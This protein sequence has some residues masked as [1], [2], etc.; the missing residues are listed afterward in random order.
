[1]IS[2]TRSLCSVLLLLTCLHAAAQN[3][4]H[5]IFS[6]AHT[7]AT[8]GRL[9]SI[10]RIDNERF[11]PLSFMGRN[12]ISL[13]CR[14][15][16]PPAGKPKARYPMI[17]I[18][19]GSGA[20]GT[21]NRSQ[22]GLMAKYWARDDI[23]SRYPAY[24]LAVQF[25]TR[26]SDY[27]PDQQRGIPVS[28]HRP[29]LETALQLVDSLR[30]S[31]AVDPARIYGLGYS[32][33]ASTIL[34]AIGLRSNLFAGVVSISGVPEFSHLALLKRVPLLLVHGNADTENVFAGSAQ[35]FKELSNSP[36]NRVQFWEIK[37]AT[38]DM[39]N[40]WLSQELPAWLFA[41]KKK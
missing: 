26:S 41:Q 4:R 14:L 29:C 5:R 31:L 38:H 22:L 19:H 9:D 20:V 16:P 36:N 17:I 30:G 34:N 32:M 6:L 8:S 21:D 23:R 11:Q 33:G 37:D 15:L 7:E 3:T 13:Q 10:R 12:G 35:L 25:P 2:V 28:H 24:V 18:F 27:D 1:M 40:L 39:S